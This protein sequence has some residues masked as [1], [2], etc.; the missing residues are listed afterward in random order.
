MNMEPQDSHY[1]ISSKTK[2]QS[3]IRPAEE[4]DTR[5]IANLGAKTFA[6]TFGHSLPAADL[7]TYLETAFSHS[8]INSDLANP[9]IDVFVAYDNSHLGRVMGFVQL[10]Q[11]TI[12][13]CLVGV[14]NPIELQRLYIAEE[15]H[16]TGVGGALVRYVEQLARE[17]GFATMWLGVWEEN[18]KAQMV[19]ERLGFKRIGEHDFVLGECVQTD[20]I[21]MKIL[22]TKGG[23]N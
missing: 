20:W 22:R 1:V 2:R 5:E 14:E 9:L 13:A 21:L 23:S 6:S 8:A 17:R 11:G 10:T 16:G 7:Q 12:E 15:Y 19:Y 4:R 18:I 3:M